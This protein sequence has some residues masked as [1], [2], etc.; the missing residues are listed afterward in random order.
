MLY[1]PTGL[2]VTAGGSLQEAQSTG[3]EGHG[4]ITRLGWRR[5]LFELGETKLAVD[6]TKA[7]DISTTNSEEVSAGA[8]LFQNVD[9]AGLQLYTGYR[10]HDVD[11]GSPDLDD[12]HV[13]VFGAAFRF[14]IA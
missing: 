5:L 14:D 2:D 6:Y 3:H 7:W 9:A 12:I 10:L 4:F 13:Y 11:L 1:L 8:F